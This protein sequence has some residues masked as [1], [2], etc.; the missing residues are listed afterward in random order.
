MN[1]KAVLSVLLVGSL[2]GVGGCAVKEG[3]VGMPVQK[4]MLIN[5]PWEVWANDDRSNYIMPSLIFY[6]STV[7]GL[8]RGDT[9]FYFSYELRGRHLLLKDVNGRVEKSRILQL[10]PNTLTVDRLWFLEGKQTYHRKVYG[11]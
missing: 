8:S 10:G 9:V 3:T 11:P 6:D 4:E 2:L 1:S 7:T 5:K